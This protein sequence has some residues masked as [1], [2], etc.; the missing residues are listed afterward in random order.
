MI[1]LIKFEMA[2]ITK[3]K[4]FGGA[5]LIMLIVVLAVILAT[6]Y[7]TNLISGTAG[8]RY[9]G[10]ETANRNA[11]IANAYAG[12]LT[13]AKISD[14][15]SA[16]LQATQEN[17]QQIAAG[18]DKRDDFFGAFPYQIQNTFISD[19]R[20]FSLQIDAAFE[21]HQTLSLSDINYY[22]IEDLNFY[23]AKN[24]TSPVQMGNN[25]PW[26]E[27]LETVGR[28][29][30]PLALFLILI[31]ANLFSME[32]S[33]NTIP[34]VATT[35]FGPTKMIYA[36]IITACVITISVYLLFQVVIFLSFF[37]LYG[38]SGWQ[39]S[40]QANF[41]WRLFDFPI[42]LNQVQVLLISYG[43]QLAALLATVG[44]TSLIAI[45]AKNPFNSLAIAL[46]VFFAPQLLREFIQSGIIAKFLS[47]FPINNGDPG[48]FF[49]TL[50]SGETFFTDNFLVNISLLLAFFLLAKLLFDAIICWRMKQLNFS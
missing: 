50:A 45:F 35:K 19:K 12:D 20:E 23:G 15:L 3:E 37:Y 11:E 43:V 25:L 17:K 6:L 26:G 16:Y 7:G 21:E 48:T 28:A 41:P 10:Q 30:L 27:L 36:K 29:F 42:L 34:V 8:E 40:I 44:F 22:S 13:D 46:G 33:R 1:D 31:C 9:A 32:F 38:L 2:K 24:G 14:I 49:R 4:I 39:V 47:L 18:E 5:F